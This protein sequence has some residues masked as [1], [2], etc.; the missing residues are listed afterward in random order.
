MA[1]ASALVDDELVLVVLKDSSWIIM[2]FERSTNT[3][4]QPRFWFSLGLKEP[5]VQMSI[6]WYFCSFASLLGAAVSKNCF[7]VLDVLPWNSG[8]LFKLLIYFYGK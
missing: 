7:T 2:L 1:I 4:L 6:W 3:T 8:S 5:S